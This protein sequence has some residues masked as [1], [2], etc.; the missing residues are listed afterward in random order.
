MVCISPILCLVISVFSLKAYDC[1]EVCQRSLGP[2]VL[3]R[4]PQTKNL[5][6]MR[7]A[8]I[9]FK[10]FTFAYTTTTTADPILNE[11]LWKEERRRR[12]SEK[13][14]AYWYNK[15]EY[16]KREI[17]KIEREWMEGKIRAEENLKAL[18]KEVG[19]RFD[20]NMQKG[21]DHW[22]KVRMYNDR[23]GTTH[24]P[25]SKWMKY[26]KKLRFES[27]VEFTVPNPNLT[28]TSKYKSIVDMTRKWGYWLPVTLPG[29][30]PNTEHIF[31]EVVGKKYK[32]DPWADLKKRDREI[33][34]ISSSAEERKI[35][36]ISHQFVSS[37]EQ[38]LKIK[39]VYTERG[40]TTTEHSNSTEY[41]SD[42]AGYFRDSQIDDSE[43]DY[44]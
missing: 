16:E 26:W 2:T 17:E 39:Y 12:Q 25:G 28:T 22:L 42:S 30:E 40:V 8:W 21:F 19:V 6:R 23:H 27:H 24:K 44:Y 33:Y 35:F 13:M 43:E 38:E 41:E 15:S 4:P 5:H 9:D 20:E 3:I 7:R 14:K 29:I 31:S 34:N 37:E 11:E 1:H 10:N 32:K 18:E 36:N